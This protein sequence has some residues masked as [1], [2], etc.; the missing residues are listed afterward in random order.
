MQGKPSPS[1]P[2]SGFRSLASAAKPAQVCYLRTADGRMVEQ[3]I[4]TEQGNRQRIPK[5]QAQG[6]GNFSRLTPCSEKEGIKLTRR[7]ER[8]LKSIVPV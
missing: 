6:Y 7:L 4:K 2:V 5:G 8:R 3:E 1:R